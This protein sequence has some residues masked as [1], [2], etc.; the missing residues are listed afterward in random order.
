MADDGLPSGPE[1]L[2][3]GRRRHDAPGGCCVGDGD[4]A[5]LRWPAA[6]PLVVFADT[7]DGAE[8]ELD[9]LTPRESVADVLLSERPAPKVRLL[10]LN[11]PDRLNAMNAELC[12]ALHDELATIAADRSCRAVVLTGAGRGSAPASTSAATAHAPGND[13]SDAARDQLGNQEHMSRLILQLRRPRSRSSPPSTGRP[14]GFGLALALGSDIRYA[15]R[16]AVF[17]AAFINIGAVQLRHGDELAAA[18]PDRRLARA[19]ADAHGPPRRRRGGRAHRP[20]GGRRSTTSACSSGALEGAEQIAAL[21]PWGVRLTKQGMWTALEI[22]SEQA[23]IEYEDRQQIM[24][25][26]G[27][28]PP[29]AIAAFLEKRPA[30]FADLTGRAPARPVRPRRS[31]VVAAR[32]RCAKDH[33]LPRPS[34]S[35]TTTPGQAT[36]RAP[37][38]CRCG[39]T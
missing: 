2:V 22:P 17:R 37:T 18:A 5:G 36:T 11:R 29:E 19:R 33:A 9:R 13:G 20:R 34:A 27:T 16:S 15:A 14:A 39:A 10:T 30:E 31:A 1:A 26:H 21:A 32:R 38:T 4:N 7:R 3:R 25:L 8:V 24:A 6:A 12:A 35:S 28:A 23:A